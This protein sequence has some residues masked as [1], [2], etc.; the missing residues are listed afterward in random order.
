[1]DHMIAVVA[2]A[3]IFACL[4]LGSVAFIVCL[5]VPAGRKYALS[6][7]F[8]FA[9]WGPCLATVMVCA[10]LGMAAGSYAARSEGVQAA[11]PARLLH[12]IGTGTL[13]VGGIATLAVST[14]TAWLHQAL[15]HRF[16]FALF[17]LYATAVCAGIGS[18][19]GWS[20]VL[21]MEAIWP[22]SPTTWLAF[23]AIPLCAAVGGYLAFHNPR[24]LRG[25]PPKSLTWITTEEFHGTV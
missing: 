22:S 19:F 8:W 3:L 2:L 11:D 24:G 5:A 15:I 13:I 16:T 7:A 18:V 10:L 21:C 1:M 9:L 25:Q 17:R 14:G 6:T 20:I 23:P 4:V 12:W